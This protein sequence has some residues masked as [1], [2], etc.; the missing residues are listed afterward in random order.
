[1]CV[2]SAKGLHMRV[3]LRIH[4]AEVTNPSTRAVPR[5]MRRTFPFRP[6]RFVRTDPFGAG[7]GTVA[8]PSPLKRAPGSG[9]GCRRVPDRVDPAPTGRSPEMQPD[10][11]AACLNG[12]FTSQAAGPHSTP[13]SGFPFQPPGN[14]ARPG[15]RRSPFPRPGDLRNV[16]FSP[17][18]VRRSHLGRAIRPASCRTPLRLRGSGPAESPRCLWRC[19]RR[20][21]SRACSWR[22]IRSSRWAN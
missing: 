21:S 9:A 7:S 17:P 1:M 2:R 18:S 4:D 3:E 16:I 19:L 6:S 15:G 20:C 13:R 11:G 22:G 10:P 5:K 12:I 8:P 14:P